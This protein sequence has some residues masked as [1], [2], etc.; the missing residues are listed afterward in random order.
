[1]LEQRGDPDFSKSTG[2]FS[3]HLYCCLL[4][5]RTSHSRTRIK[6]LSQV[7]TAA[8]GGVRNSFASDLR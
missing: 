6:P 5:S 8:P 7:V 4:A 3:P 1:M 2:G